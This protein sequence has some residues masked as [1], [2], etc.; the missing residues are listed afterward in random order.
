MASTFSAWGSVPKRPG[1]KDAGENAGLAAR[2]IVYAL[3]ELNNLVGLSMVYGFTFHQWEDRGIHFINLSF[4][5][6]N[7]PEFK[8]SGS[9]EL[10]DIY[11]FCDTV[12]KCLQLVSLDFLI[13]GKEVNSHVYLDSHK[14]LKVVNNRNG[15]DYECSRVNLKTLVR[16]WLQCHVGLDH[17]DIQTQRETGVS[18]IT[19][20][21]KRG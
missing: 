3:E 2:D 14:N 9:R 19:V 21:D 13:E 6:D 16:G 18:S 7:T 10:L 17:G 5:I 15:H 1:I 8:C 20:V 4:T 12:S 11:K